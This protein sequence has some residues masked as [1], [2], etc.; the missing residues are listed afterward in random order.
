MPV[1]FCTDGVELSAHSK[2]R[3]AASM[4]SIAAEASGKR[5]T[6]NSEAR[7][8][9][10]KVNFDDRNNNFQFTPSRQP[11]SVSCRTSPVLMT[12]IFNPIVESTTGSSGRLME[13]PGCDPR[14]SSERTPRK[15][16]RRSGK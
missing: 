5:A 15:G 12:T 8:T 10:K 2:P 13:R 7:L 1:Q 3:S 16:S 9:R 6:P 4:P 14:Q 11:G